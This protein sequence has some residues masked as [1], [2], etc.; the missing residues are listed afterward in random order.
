MSRK[1]KIELKLE[2]RMPI[3]VDEYYAIRLTIE[4][5]EET[6]IDNLL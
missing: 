6:K 3:F 2:H 1:A 5:R 4:N